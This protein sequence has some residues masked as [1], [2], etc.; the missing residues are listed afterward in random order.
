MVANLADLEVFFLPDCPAG[1]LYN[2]TVNK[3][4]AV[5]LQNVNWDTAG[6]ACLALNGDAHLAVIDSAAAQ[7]A[8]FQT[9]TAYYREC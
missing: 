1:F 8:V 3:C 7:A 4:Y 2:A 5:G 9:I 6:R